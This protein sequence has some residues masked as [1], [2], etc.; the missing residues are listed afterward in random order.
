MRVC[1]FHHGCSAE[2]Q[3]IGRIV[4]KPLATVNREKRILP[5][6]FKKGDSI[7]VVRGPR[8]QKRGLFADNATVATVE[9]LI[10]E[11]HAVAL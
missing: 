8:E 10:H 11:K 1:Q 2:Q 6:R 7:R 9:G 3:N 4:E 5:T